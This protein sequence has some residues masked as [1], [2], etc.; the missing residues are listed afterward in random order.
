MGEEKIKLSLN[1]IAKTLEKDKEFLVQFG[2]GKYLAVRKLATDEQGTFVSRAYKKVG[3]D[4]Y[5]ELPYKTML[6]QT[7]DFLSKSLNAKSILMDALEKIEPEDAVDIFERIQK[8]PKITT[9]RQ[10]GSCSFL[11]IR[12]KRGK[13][14]AL[15]LT[16]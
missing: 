6:E 4:I 10:K 11:Y 12:G 7:A 14:T 9:G 3:D 8:K 5:E 16:E 15:Q 1:D 2:K 13:P